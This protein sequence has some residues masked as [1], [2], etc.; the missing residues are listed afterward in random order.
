MICTEKNSVDFR[1]SDEMDLSEV[2]EK[3]DMLKKKSLYHTVE[4]IL[5]FSIQ[6][7]RFFSGIKLIA[8]KKLNWK[9]LLLKECC[10]WCSVPKLCLTHCHPID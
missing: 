3:S 9:L 4:N 1:R 8:E 6:G 5:Y 7:S 2:L 10:C